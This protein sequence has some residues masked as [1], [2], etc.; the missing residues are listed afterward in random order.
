MHRHLATDDAAQ[1]APDQP[2]VHSQRPPTHLPRP[3]Q[4]EGQLASGEPRHA[5]V[6]PRAPPCESSPFESY[7]SVVDASHRGRSQNHGDE[8]LYTHQPW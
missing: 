1:L 5:T 4:P 8:S 7:L 3:E 6:P 2:G